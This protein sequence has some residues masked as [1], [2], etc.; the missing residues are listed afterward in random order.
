MPL[1]DSVLADILLVS[2]SAVTVRD[3]FLVAPFTRNTPNGYWF[4]CPTVLVV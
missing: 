1:F 4:L 3:I 2:V